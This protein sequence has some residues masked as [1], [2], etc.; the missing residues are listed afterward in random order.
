MGDGGVLE[1]SRGG[2]GDG[3]EET[4]P[5]RPTA[6]QGSQRPQPLLPVPREQLPLPVP[7]LLSSRVVQ[8]MSARATWTRMNSALSGSPCSSSQSA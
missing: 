8:G 4:P 1:V 2:D 5:E 6:E 7:Q 3:V